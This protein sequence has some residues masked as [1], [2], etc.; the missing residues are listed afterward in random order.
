[1]NFNYYYF[2]INE[3][4]N[5]KSD[6]KIMAR[7]NNLYNTVVHSYIAVLSF[8]LELAVTSTTST[9]STTITTSIIST[10]TPTSTTIKPTTTNLDY[11]MP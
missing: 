8:L 5:L 11:I 4:E 3:L 10:T 7:G 9:T 1:M 6:E 2:Q